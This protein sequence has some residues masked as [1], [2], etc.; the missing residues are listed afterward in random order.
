MDLISDIETLN[1]IIREYFVI[2]TITNNYVLVETYTRHIADKRL[3]YV[4]AGR[5]AGILVKT[6]DYY[7]LYYYIN[8][9]AELMVPDSIEPI[10]MEILFRGEAHRP[11]EIIAYWEKCGFRQHLTRNLM[12]ASYNQ[13]IL[14]EGQSSDIEI[15]YAVSDMEI[16]FSKDLIESTFDKYTGD[17][18]TLEEIKSFVKNK[19]I[20]C[21]YLSGNLCGILQSEIKNSVVWLGHIAVKPEFRG[22]GIAKALVRKYIINN[23]MQPNTKFHLW[24]IQ[25]NTQATNLYQQFGFVYGNKSSVSMLKK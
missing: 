18:L 3:F 16:V 13:L 1:D 4:T 24:V 22:N 10:M 12:M 5:N 11:R 14:P 8:D 9:Q 25:N 2:N 19:S 15:R 17:I 23:A 6:L 21:A 20:I 7:K